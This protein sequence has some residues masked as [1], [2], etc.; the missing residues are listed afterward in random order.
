LK[1]NSSQKTEDSL[2]IRR[3]AREYA[4]QLLFQYD[5]RR[6]TL[7]ETVLDDFQCQYKDIEIALGSK[8][9]SKISRLATTIS[10]GVI[11]NIDFIDYVITENAHHWRLERM[12][13][14][15]RNVIRIAV[16]EMLYISDIPEAVSI[17]EAIEIAKAYGS[18]QSAKFVNGILDMINKQKRDYLGSK[19]STESAAK[20]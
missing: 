10:H 16:Y 6:E 15:D 4:M 8:E 19:P 3:K 12:P 18:D 14:V 1:I 11:G 20:S 9:L 2:P 5:L 7:T 17:N 13:A